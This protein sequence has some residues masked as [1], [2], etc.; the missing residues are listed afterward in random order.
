MRM[1]IM[2][3]LAL[4]VALPHLATAVL[5]D[6]LQGAAAVDRYNVVWDSPS[7][8][9][10]GS[11]PLGNG[12]IGLN[13][14]VENH[15]D[16]V[17]YI[18][19]T[20]AWNEHDMLLKLGRV[21]VKLTP[22]PFDKG[23]PF[24]QELR[25]REGQ[26]VV[27]AGKDPA[28]VTLRVWVD[29]NCPVIHVQAV[30]HSAF[31]MRAQLELWRTEPRQLAGEEANAC[32][33]MTLGK[34]PIIVYPDTILPAKNHCL[35]WYHRNEKS[36]YATVMNEEQLGELISKYRDPYLGRTFGGRIDGEG[37]VAKDNRTLQ[38]S[39]PARQFNLDIHLLTAQTGTADAWGKQLEEQAARVRSTPLD[40]AWQEHARWWNDFWDRSWIHVAPAA[41]GPPAE[42][43]RAEVVS[44]GYA[45]QRFILACAGRGAQ[46]IK[47]NGSI[48]TV[49]D[50]GRGYN[51]DYRAWGGGYW[52]QNTRLAYWPMLA[53]G[54]FDL[55]QPWFQMYTACLPLMKD[56]TRI[57]YQHDGA[58]FVETMLF[59]GPPAPCD[60][61]WGNRGPEMVNNY[62]KYYWSGG[63]ELLTMMVD[64]YD[65]TEDAQYAQKT[66]LPLADAV[67]TFFDQHWKRGPDGKI[68]FEPSQ[69]LET[70]INERQYSTL[71]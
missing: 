26:I 30:G 38:S 43:Q 36:C 13:V 29:A 47:F 53:A 27:T 52:F 28:A 32:R 12:D 66:L 17:F 55:M 67:I 22:N 59:W 23:V 35:R 41:A 25:L 39:S 10:S 37:L 62:I 71:F 7:A 20:D 60:W 45:L 48:F 3:L 1:P 40:Q 65:Q 64:Y 42:R 56:R 18:S 68:R 2:L 44:R 46:P 69:S 15:G 63:L 16:L 70:W 57:Y 14:W 54:D 49:D 19:K 21:R 51:A 6:T 5:A 31:E 50:H 4:L 11:M 8:D 58:C 33:E 61:G 34:Y 24:R 9:S